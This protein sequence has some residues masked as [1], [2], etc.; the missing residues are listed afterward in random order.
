MPEGGELGALAEGGGGASEVLNLYLK[1][2]EGE[3]VDEPVKEGQW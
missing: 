1:C 3:V 2:R